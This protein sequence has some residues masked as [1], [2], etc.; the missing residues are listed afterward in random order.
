VECGG[1]R[2]QKQATGQLD[3]RQSAPIVVWRTNMRWNVMVLNREPDQWYLAGTMAAF[4]G[5]PPFGW[6]QRIDPDTLSPMADNGE[7]PCGDHVWCGSIAAHANG[8]LYNV[9]GSYLHRLSAD[10][11]VEIEARLPVD[12]ATN[13]STLTVSKSAGS[14][15]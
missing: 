10:C 9:N 11:H 6:V 15:D 13:C 8:S 7:P 12:Q 3:T 14:R 1:N 4:E 2:R 5:E